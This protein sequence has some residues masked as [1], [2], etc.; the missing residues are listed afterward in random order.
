M[1]IYENK[2]NGRLVHSYKFT[3]ENSEF[4]INKLINEHGFDKDKATEIV[5]DYMDVNDVVVLPH[6]EDG[7]ANRREFDYGV[8]NGNMFLEEYIPFTVKG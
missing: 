3:G 4:I 2:G 8:M 7:L 5:N 1:A 6:D